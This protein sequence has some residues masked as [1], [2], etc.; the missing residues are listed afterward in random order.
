VESEYGVGST[1]WF[2]LDIA[3]S[4]VVLDR[5][6]GDSETDGIIGYAGPRKKI[7]IADDIALN[8]QVL[9]EMLEPLGFIIVQAVDGRQ[10][11]EI[12]QRERPDLVL[13]DIFMPIIDGV[14]F[15][16]NARQ[17][18]GFDVL[19]IIPVS[20]SVAELEMSRC[21]ALDCH[22][23]LAKPVEYPKLMECL[24]R[25]LNLQWIV[26]PETTPEK[27]D[28]PENFEP[29]PP[30]PIVEAKILSNLAKQGNL[31]ALSAAVDKLVTEQPKYASFSLR[32]RQLIQEFRMKPIRQLIDEHQPENATE[33]P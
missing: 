14:Q 29:S 16:Q 11:L 23:F 20:A 2:E 4:A 10:A 25:R 19:P 1:F 21:H 9:V 5:K 7:L 31:K 6:R 30:L 22:D 3:S 33:E 15:I 24:K 28:V 13:T 12:L 27:S 18:T 32:M 26:N 17:M 8:R